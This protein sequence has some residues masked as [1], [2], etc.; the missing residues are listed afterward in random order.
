MPVGTSGQSD[1]PLS[2]LGNLSPPPTTAINQSS[3]PFS[4][5]GS[6]TAPPTVVMSQSNDPFGNLGNL[7][8]PAIGGSS[9]SNDPFA[10]LA[11]PST[12]PVKSAPVATANT[13]NSL[14]A[15]TNPTPLIS[16][17]TATPTAVPNYN[18]ND[19]VVPLETITPGEC[20]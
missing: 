19:L 14:F 13:T 2:L 4:N 15:V 3:D 8:A 16:A 10:Y 11:N 20:T 5:L 6:L 1:D 7:M 9:Q 12:V 17:D 18:F